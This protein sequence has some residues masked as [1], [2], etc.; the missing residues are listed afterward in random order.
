V[1]SGDIIVVCEVVC[2]HVRS[3]RG[4]VRH[5]C[6]KRVGWTLFEGHLRCRVFKVFLFLE[7][8]LYLCCENNNYVYH[9]RSNLR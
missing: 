5:I 8:N 3:S 4:D 1:P 9:G 6:S 2:L 7:L